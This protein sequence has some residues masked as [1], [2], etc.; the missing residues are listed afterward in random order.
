MELRHISS[1]F[2]EPLENAGLSLESIHDEIEEAVDYVRIE[3][4]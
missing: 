3:D 1:L 2:R 4:T